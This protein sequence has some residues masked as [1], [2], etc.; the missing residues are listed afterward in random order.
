[1][2][3]L[4][5]KVNLELDDDLK[6]QID[7]YVTRTAFQFGLDYKLEK[8]NPK[9]DDVLIMRLPTDESGETIVDF[10]SALS[11]FNSI[12]NNVDCEVIALPDNYALD[13]MDDCTFEIYVEALNEVL[14]RRKQI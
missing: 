9:K 12:N 8:I 5:I 4:K 2:S 3:D 14:K 13:L 1:M 10:E 7:D 11:Y 6:N